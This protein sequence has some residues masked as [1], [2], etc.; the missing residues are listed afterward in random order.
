MVIGGGRTYTDL[1]L[2]VHAEDW[3]SLNGEEKTM[4]ILEYDKDPSTY[5]LDYDVEQTQLIRI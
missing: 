3:A 4:A 2:I 5:G 1:F